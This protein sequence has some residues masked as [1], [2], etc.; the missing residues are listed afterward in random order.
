M[1]E[2]LPIT[3]ADYQ[4]WRDLW[5]G[6]LEFYQAEISEEVTQET[7]ERILSGAIHGL[8]AKDVSGGAVG[9]VHWLTHKSTWTIPEVCYLEDLF[10]HHD[11]RGQGIGRALIERVF[12]WAQENG[13]NKVYW[14][15]AENNQTARS[16]YDQIANKTAFIHYEIKGD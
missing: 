15:T 3:R 7:F 9:L 16:V 2:L 4:S 13:M 5:D 1:F 10:V 6:Y 8:L 11:S 12:R 14:L